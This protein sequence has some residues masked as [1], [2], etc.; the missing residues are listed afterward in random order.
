V[1]GGALGRDTL[2]S[3]HRLDYGFGSLNFLVSHENPL[4]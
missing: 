1:L 4:E 3:A 2:A